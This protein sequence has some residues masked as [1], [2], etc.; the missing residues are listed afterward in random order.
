MVKNV[1]NKY[2]LQFTD[3][4]L[5]NRQF[6]IILNQMFVMEIMVYF[7]L[8]SKVVVFSCWVNKKVPGHFFLLKLLLKE[9]AKSAATAWLASPLN[10]LSLAIA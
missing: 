3:S 4:I 5:N 6:Y 7:F 2:H 9:S 10:C 1:T 8:S